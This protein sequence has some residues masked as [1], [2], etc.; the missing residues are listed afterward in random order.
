MRHIHSDD[1]LYA[2]PEDILQICRA[3]RPAVRHFLRKS[4]AARNFTRQTSVNRRERVTGFVLRSVTALLTIVLGC[5]AVSI[6]VV[7]MTTA[8]FDE[9]ATPTQ[10][11]IIKQNATSKGG[12]CL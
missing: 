9:P 3:E 6:L 11:G 5:L 4:R 12:V 7:N 8:V 10:T 1:Y 2:S